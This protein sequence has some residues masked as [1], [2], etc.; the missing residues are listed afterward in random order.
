MTV[1]ASPTVAEILSEIYL[2]C[3]GSVWVLQKA[4]MA[5]VYDAIHS[6]ERSVLR[7]ARRLA[8]VGSRGKSA[9]W[10]PALAYCRY[11]YAVDTAASGVVAAG[12]GL[13]L[14]IIPCAMSHATLPCHFATA[15]ALLALSVT[16]N[17]FTRLNYAFAA[18]EAWVRPAVPAGTGTLTLHYIEIPTLYAAATTAI[19]YDPALILPVAIRAAQSL[20]L[21]WPSTSGEKVQ[22]LRAEYDTEIQN[23]M[24]GLGEDVQREYARR[25]GLPNG[26]PA[27]GQGGA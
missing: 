11:P 13:G 17:R 27:P 10:D 23:L 1:P 16:D 14:D 19:T 2:R 25:T 18:G 6:A 22:A 4:G 12:L 3:N 5:A 9:T 7:H 21:K 26:A 8:F 24:M 15:E 20:C